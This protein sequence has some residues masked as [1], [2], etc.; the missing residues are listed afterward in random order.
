MELTSTLLLCNDM[1][2]D[3]ADFPILNYIR[4]YRNRFIAHPSIKR[5][6]SDF[7]SLANIGHHPEDPLKLP[8]TNFGPGSGSDFFCSYHKLKGTQN[9]EKEWDFMHN[10]NYED[11]IKMK[12]SDWENMPLEV[13]SRI[14]T[15]GLPNPTEMQGYISQEAKKLFLDN[16][17]P[18]IEK[19]I[20]FVY[21]KYGR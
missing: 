12:R 14:I 16:I 15:Y 10:K 3:P 4:E 6:F 21:V 2:I 1:N 5:P 20:D 7:G 18:Y 13:R 9:P 17:I 8:D 11:F 19:Q